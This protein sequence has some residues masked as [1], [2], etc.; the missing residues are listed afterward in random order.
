[1][2]AGVGE[3]RRWRIDALLAALLCPRAHPCSVHPP[4][5]L[6]MADICLP[7]YNT[8]MV[9]GAEKQPLRP[10]VSLKLPE[11]LWGAAQGRTQTFFNMSW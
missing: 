9:S 4:G 10:A 5:L 3:C 1:V 7:L 11:K 8:C 6:W 2:P